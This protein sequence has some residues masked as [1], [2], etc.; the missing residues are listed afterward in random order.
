M[1]K[2]SNK[3]KIIQTKKFVKSYRKLSSKDKDLTDKLMDIL[4]TGEVLPPKY[5]DHQL[6]G[7]LQNLRE[8]HIRGDLV[9]LYEKD[10]EIL[11]L[12]AINV[13]THSQIF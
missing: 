7:T 5:C 6:K 3:F 12:V 8:C 2:S 13:G 9:F 11:T 4:R 10:G 1:A